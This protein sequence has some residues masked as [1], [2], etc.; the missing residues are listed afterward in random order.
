ME[1]A[2][3][4]EGGKASGGPPLGPAVGPYRYSYQERCWSDQRKDT[5]IQRAQITVTVIVDTSDKTFE[6]KIS[7][8]SASAL[9]FKEGGFEGG[10][11]KAKETK[12]GD[13]S[14][15]QILN[16]AKMKRDRWRL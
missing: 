6:I 12:A 1:I 5:G 10:S 14:F 8:P 2:L 7:T 9:L 15:E 16:V 13:L 11:G 4:V 3:L